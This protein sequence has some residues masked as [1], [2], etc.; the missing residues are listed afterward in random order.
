MIEEKSRLSQ[1]KMELNSLFVNL[2][3]DSSQKGNNLFPAMKHFVSLRE[4][5]CFQC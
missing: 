3:H 4:T 5:S 2:F 1:G